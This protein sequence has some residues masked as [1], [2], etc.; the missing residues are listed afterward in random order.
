MKEAFDAARPSDLM[1]GLIGGIS[2]FTLDHCVAWDCGRFKVVVCIRLA[3]F[4]QAQRS[5]GCFSDVAQHASWNP[6][7]LLHTS[8]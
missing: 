1:L 5:I 6:G 2:R 3:A 7:C 8:L 4:T